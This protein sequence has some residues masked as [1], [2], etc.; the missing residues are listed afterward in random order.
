MDKEKFIKEYNESIN[1][2]REI[3]ISYY[4]LFSGWYVNHTNIEDIGLDDIKL[5]SF[6]MRNS[7]LME[8]SI[9]ENNSD[10]LLNILIGII[11]DLEK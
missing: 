2:L 11:I 7:I 5:A 6:F 10:S 9:Y 8:Q 4:N 1:K 3:S